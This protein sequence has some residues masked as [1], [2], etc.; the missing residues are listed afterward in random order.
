[1]YSAHREHGANINALHE[2]RSALH[3]AVEQESID[4]L[5]VLISSEARIVKYNGLT[6]LEYAIALER[7]IE[8]IEVLLAYERPSKIHLISMIEN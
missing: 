5:K 8:V 7:S 2:E 4:K 1:M 3:I 6:P